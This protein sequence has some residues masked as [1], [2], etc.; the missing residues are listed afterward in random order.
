MAILNYVRPT[1]HGTAYGIGG[2]CV[3]VGCIPKKIMHH[4][5][6]MSTAAV[7]AG[8]FGWDWSARGSVNWTQ[9]VSGVQDYI[10]G[11]NFGYRTALREEGIELV[12]SWGR[13]TSSGQ[14]DR[15]GIECLRPVD[16][17]PHQASAG[18]QD[19]DPAQYTHAIPG[20]ASAGDTPWSVHRTLT[21]KH[22]VIAVGGRP[23][24]PSPSELPGVHHAITSDDLFSLPRTPGR[25]VVVGGGYVALE[26]AGLLNGLGF[27]TTLVLRSVP[28][29]GFDSE[30]AGRVL[31]SL[32][33]EGVRV[34]RGCVPA[35]IVETRDWLSSRV[36]NAGLRVHF[37][38]HGTVVSGTM[39]SNAAS[40]EGAT[41]AGAPDPID[42]DTVVMATGR[43]VLTQGLGLEA[44]GVSMEPSTGKI[45]CYDKQRTETAQCAD[46]ANIHA[47]GDVVAGRQ[48]L[49]PVASRA[50]KVLAR[51]L[52][53]H[54]ARSNPQLVS[55]ATG[56]QG[57]S[58]L[59][60]QEALPA[61]SKPGQQLSFDSLFNSPGPREQQ[62]GL[63]ASES[64]RTNAPLDFASLLTP[65]PV[66]DISLDL[67]SLK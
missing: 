40:P 66:G 45:L 19:R 22:A 62:K 7:E 65:K 47:I 12:E 42:A 25:T 10:H 6:G 1:S 55:W 14:A 20:S 5:A 32:E 8:S 67:S 9:L 23:V 44:L 43:R 13:L 30:M 48:E 57:L 63:S 59:G 52:F 38:A 21:S 27:E 41:D 26:T 18:L 36:A 34:L 17:L 31:C 60:G 24:L 35:S 49:T 37:K 64:P 58:N 50:G 29:R 56:R 11:Q 3:N 28:L 33:A 2:T 54:L 4:A 39:G 16:P 51:H 46:R 15:L 53:S 61:A